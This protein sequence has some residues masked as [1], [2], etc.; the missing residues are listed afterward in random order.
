[1]AVP[2]GSQVFVGLVVGRCRLC[3]HC[4]CC[5]CRGGAGHGPDSAMSLNLNIRPIPPHPLAGMPD[6]GGMGGGAR[7]GGPTVEEVD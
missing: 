1:M 7:P 4:C 2:G 5:C 3:R 6:M